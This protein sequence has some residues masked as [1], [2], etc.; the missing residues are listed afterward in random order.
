MT[1][2]NGFNQKI[3]YTGGEAGVIRILA[4]VAVLFHGGNCNGNNH[5]NNKTI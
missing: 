2:D 1:Y 5:R 3:A 4:I